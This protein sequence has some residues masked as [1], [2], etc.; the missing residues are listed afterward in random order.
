MEGEGVNRDKISLRYA[1]QNTLI[2]SIFECY[3]GRERGRGGMWSRDPST[4]MRERTVCVIQENLGV[5]GRA[6]SQQGPHAV[7]KYHKRNTH[8]GRPLNRD[9]PSIRAEVIGWYCATLDAW[10]ILIASRHG[11]PSDCDLS[12][13][14]VLH[15]T[16]RLYVRT[17]RVTNSASWEERTWTWTIP[18]GPIAVSGLFIYRRYRYRGKSNSQHWGLL[19][20]SS[21]VYAYV[22]ELN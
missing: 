17:Q 18:I 2:F 6:P 22:N 13:H 5:S 4:V 15:T 19:Y 3:D 1:W 8:R 10:G 11:F 16:F 14:R 21:L 7:T 9:G 20:G 12:V